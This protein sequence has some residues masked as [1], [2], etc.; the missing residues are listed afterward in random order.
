MDRVFD[1]NHSRNPAREDAEYV[2]M[3]RMKQLFLIRH[4]ET[5]WSKDGRHTGRSDLPLT[6]EGRS[7]AEALRSLLPGGTFDQILCSPMQ[8]AVRTAELAG[9]P[10]GSL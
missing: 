8:R 7:R 2:R 1:F 3:S 5:E 4:G 6:A 10:A 9:F